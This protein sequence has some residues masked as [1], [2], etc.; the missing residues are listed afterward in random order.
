MTRAGG[1]ARA[2]AMVRSRGTPGLPQRTAGGLIS[3]PA[4]SAV[5]A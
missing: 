4:R 1:A 5:I 3:E 2:G